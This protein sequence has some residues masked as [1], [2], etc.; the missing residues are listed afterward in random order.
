MD[1]SRMFGGKPCHTRRLLPRPDPCVGM[2]PVL[3]GPVPAGAGTRRVP[4]LEWAQTQT[5]VHKRLAAETVWTQNSLNH[6]NHSLQLSFRSTINNAPLDSFQHRTGTKCY[7]SR[8]SSSSFFSLT[9]NNPPSQTLI[10][11]NCVLV[12]VLFTFNL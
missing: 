11:L 8:H 4:K 12:R 1:F 3:F 7:S 5:D 9:V 10:L 6:C 2:S